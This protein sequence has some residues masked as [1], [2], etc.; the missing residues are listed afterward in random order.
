MTFEMFV[1]WADWTEFE[2]PAWGEWAIVEDDWKAYIFCVNTN[3][4]V[5]A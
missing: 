5:C 2:M 4:L 1:F 3:F